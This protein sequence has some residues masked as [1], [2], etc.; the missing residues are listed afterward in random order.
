MTLGLEQVY[1]EFPERYFNTLGISE[2]NT[3]DIDLKTTTEISVTGSK[4]GY[5]FSARGTAGR[6]AIGF[7]LAYAVITLIQI[8]LVLW[9]SWSCTDLKS[10]YNLVNLAVSSA[11]G[12]PEEVVSARLAQLKERNLNVKAEER[13]DTELRV[14]IGSHS[15]SHIANDRGGRMRRGGITREIRLLNLLREMEERQ[16]HAKLSLK[17]P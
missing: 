13:A 5:G 16:I 9:Y 8:V 11:S 15:C 17:G 7:F 14:V 6:L 4:F 10:L 3:S 2:M 1:N 12:F